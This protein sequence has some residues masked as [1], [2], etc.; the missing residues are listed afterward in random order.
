M[1]TN[2]ISDFTCRRF[3]TAFEK[4]AHLFSS[5]DD[6]SFNDKLQICSSALEALSMCELHLDDTVYTPSPIVLY[7]SVS[8]ENKSL[9]NI[10]LVMNSPFKDK[11]LAFD[12]TA[13]VTYDTLIDEVQKGINGL[14]MLEERML[15]LN[16]N[17]IKLTA[18]VSSILKSAD[19][20]ETFEF[21]F[22]LRSG[23][24]NLRESHMGIV[25]PLAVVQNLC[26][27]IPSSDAYYYQ[28]YVDE[29]V[30]T[31]LSL[32]CVIEAMRRRTR[33]STD[34]QFYTWKSA[35]TLVRA[36]YTRK[37]ENVHRGEGYI[38]RGN[39][40]GLVSVRSCNSTE[41]QEM[42]SEYG[43]SLRVADNVKPHSCDYTLA[44]NKEQLEALLAR[45]NRVGKEVRVD[46]LPPNSKGEIWYRVV[47]RPKIAWVFIFPFTDL[48][49]Y[50]RKEGITSDELL[51]Y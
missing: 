24:F 18:W 51:M 19:I 30:N 13:V 37:F 34:L 3:I 31:F 22:G 47:H 9:H 28:S 36:T 23:L 49:T 15:Y 21:T 26:N 16:Y 48:V 17:V 40:F 25:L 29:V 12:Y 27:I 39:V 50:T 38:L 4:Y 8:A 10:T 5:S 7:H 44:K 46:T 33:F 11:G 43:D 45:F 41:L 20:R 14:L 1:N 32:P 6:C 35:K 2:F 42:Q